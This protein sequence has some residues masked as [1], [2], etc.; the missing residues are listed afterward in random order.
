M[1]SRTSSAGVINRGTS[2]GNSFYVTDV[3]T[4]ADG[5]VRT[6]T[7]RTDGAGKNR[8]LIRT[9]DVNKLKEVTKNDFTS[10]TTIE[11]QR[12]FL[13]KRSTFNKLILDQVNSVK[14]DL[15]FEVNSNGGNADQIFQIAA[16]GSGNTSS[17]AVDKFLGSIGININAEKLPLNFE[18]RRRLKYDNLY[19][20]ETIATSKQDRIRFSMRY[21]SGSRDI[22]FDL[23]KGGTIGLG[24]R[25]TQGINGS[26]TLPIPGG[27]SDSNNVKFDN[28]SLDVIGALGF[29]AALNPKE[30]VEAGAEL[31]KNALNADD[32][33]LR[34]ALKGQQGS[35]LISALRIGLAQ[36]A[37]GRKGMFSRIGGGIL[38]PNME[39]L[40]QAPGMRT[41]NFSFTM[42][43][44]SRT[45]ATQIKKIIRFFKQ[46]MSV[47]RSTN[48]IFV[49]SPNTF[50]INYIL[51]NTGDDH[52]SIGRIKECALT[53]L[54]TTYGNGS[55]YMT[56]DDPDRTM[57]TYKIDMTFKELNPITEDD[58]TNFEDLAGA[59]DFMLLPTLE[60]EVAIPDN[61]IGY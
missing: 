6:E 24:E 5:G 28:D 1:A 17:N 56:F 13:N 45:E 11:E 42:S 35:N 33:A 55:T 2:G 21:I 61:H 27:I 38:N 39:L 14:S 53:D 40:F 26:V 29:G 44:R 10:N 46:G 48:N 22:N 4:L 54:N 43:A 30:A 36:A 47:K 9:I 19:Y 41:F 51:G 32:K 57:T 15:E 58:Y 20:P 59:E 3:S 49:V 50:K 25:N 16:G 7:Y 34:E 31:L 18:G 12:D 23:R 8:K 52:P 60:N 37:V